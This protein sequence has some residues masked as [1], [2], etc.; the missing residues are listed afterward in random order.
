MPKRKEIKPPRNPKDRRTS[1]VIMNR[2]KERHL[3]TDYSK[4][5]G[6]IRFGL[7]E[8]MAIIHGNELMVECIDADGFTVSISMEEAI[9]RE[10]I[11]TLDE[12]YGEGGLAEQTRE[13][14]RFRENGDLKPGPRH[15]QSNGKVDTVP[16]IRVVP[17][18]MS[19]GKA[20]WE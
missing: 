9:G 17:T 5:A 10:W 15:S 3:K 1:Q 13:L 12:I 8:P 2:K 14:F 16:G 20:M 19:G 18:P 6:V 7:K 4:A 11:P